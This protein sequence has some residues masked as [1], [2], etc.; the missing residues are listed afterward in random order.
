MIWDDFVDIFR[1]NSDYVCFRVQEVYD[2]MNSLY[3]EGEKTFD[4]IIPSVLRL[5]FNKSA[6][7]FSAD[8]MNIILLVRYEEGYGYKMKV[9][10][11]PDWSKIP[12]PHPTHE[13]SIKVDENF[14]RIGSISDIIKEQTP[15]F[16]KEDTEEAIENYHYWAAELWNVVFTSVMFMSCK[17]TIVE[18]VKPEGKIQKVRQSRGKLPLLSYH[19]LKIHQQDRPLKGESF[20]GIRMR[21]H[22]VRGHYTVHSNYFGRGEGCVLWI[23][24]HLRG[25]GSLGFVDKDYEVSTGGVNA[26][27]G[28]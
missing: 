24:E 25:D 2:V 7:S 26:N 27:K 18:E 9:C 20:S 23:N 3:G 12:L 8:G 11:P 6:F 19:L 15:D 5:P 10:I 16:I 17:R 1:E 13:S 28:L 4:E 21:L 14:R 22:K